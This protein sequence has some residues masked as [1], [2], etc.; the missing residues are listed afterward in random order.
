[1]EKRSKMQEESGNPVLFDRALANKTINV[2]LVLLG[3]AIPTAWA[4]ASYYNVDV[5]ATLIFFG[6]DGWCDIAREGIGTHC[7]GD[8]HER[9]Q[10]PYIRESPSGNNLELSPIGP[11]ITSLADLL[12]FF[13]GSRPIL[14]LVIVCY[15]CA[16]LYPVAL[17]YMHRGGRFGNVYLATLGTGSYSLLAALDRLN[18]IMLC[19]PLLIAYLHA[20]KVRNFKLLTFSIAG[21]VA[22]KPQFIFLVLVFLFLDGDRI[23]A[24]FRTLSA[25]VLS[26]TLVCFLVMSAGD[27]K[28]GRL[29]QYIHLAS[30]YSDRGGGKIHAILSWY[31]PNYSFLKPL[32]LAALPFKQ[33]AIAESFDVQLAVKL[34]VV[35][36]FLLP[37][38]L[39][40]L[41]RALV[42]STEVANILVIFSALATGYY[43]AGYYTIV[44][45]VVLCFCCISRTSE[46]RKQAVCY[47][48][49]RQALY[50][51][52]ICKNLLAIGLSFS[53]V[54]IIIPVYSLPNLRF[55]RDDMGRIATA[56][57]LISS[58][59]IMVSLAMYMTVVSNRRG[60]Y[61]NANP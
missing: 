32:H 56:S 18:N 35:I 48:Q 39:F 26:V 6:N 19:P 60:R 8:F 22:I 13:V 21:L 43:V 38:F 59:L 53:I 36:L 51:L 30:S 46:C 17:V 7:F 45:M 54:P 50:R 23:R 12:A 52:R 4:L 58:V 34:L 1:M 37:L 31:P 27:W 61:M 28:I 42:T 57:P 41:Q 9:F 20:V 10:L 16:S 15:L 24:L 47:S 2:C 44:Y 33:S 14:L 5:P 55:I 3:I 25:G 29:K 49:S 11:Y 40:W